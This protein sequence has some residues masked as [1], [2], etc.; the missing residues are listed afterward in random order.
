METGCSA[1]SN[2]VKKIFGCQI[3]TFKRDICLMNKELGLYIMKKN[4]KKEKQGAC[5]I[6][7]IPPEFK[8]HVKKCVVLAPQLSD[9]NI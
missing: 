4:K 5:V 6:G 9:Y 8:R 1:N 2:T 3:Q 7:G